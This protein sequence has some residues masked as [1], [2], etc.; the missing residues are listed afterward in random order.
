MP[1]SLVTEVFQ[2]P[3]LSA[4]SLDFSRHVI[5]VFPFRNVPALIWFPRH[6][7]HPFHTFL[8]YPH[9]F[10]CFFLSSRYPLKFF[11]QAASLFSFSLAESPY[12]YCFNCHLHVD[13]SQNLN[14]KQ[15]LWH[16]QF[17]ISA[18]YL[19]S[20]SGS[21]GFTLNSVSK[22]ES[23]LSPGCTSFSELN[24]NCISI[25]WFLKFWI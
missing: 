7:T 18:A 1:L 16:T 8:I 11:I 19:V 17:R 10:P 25:L 5:L 15:S 9:L 13:D 14:W 6:W 12:S 24:V 20:P 2:W 21:P 22:T 4:L 23:A 3:Y